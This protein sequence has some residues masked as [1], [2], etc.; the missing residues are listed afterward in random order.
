MPDLITVFTRSWKFIIGS[1]LV[2]A[3]IALVASMLSE[4]ISFCCY[5][6]AIKQC[7]I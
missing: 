5:C 1:S 6:F 4:K 7:I 3:L 2:I